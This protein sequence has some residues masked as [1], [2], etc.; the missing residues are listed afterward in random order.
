MLR[1]EV[2]AVE[3]HPGRARGS[4]RTRSGRRNERPGRPS[5][6]RASGD[7]L[8]SGARRCAVL[9]ARGARTPAGPALASPPAPRSPA[10][11]SAGGGRRTRPGGTVVY[12]VCTLNA[13]ENESVVDASGLE[14]EP[15]G[16]EWP[17]YAH[18]KRPEFL[19][20]RP[21]G[22]ARRGSSS[23]AS[24]SPPEPASGG[25]RHPSKSGGS[26]SVGWRCTSTI[27]R[28]SIGRLAGLRQG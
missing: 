22:T 17:A 13:D 21:T 27:G 10:R 23:R 28:S 14:P 15:L 2:T 26:S 11:A 24:R 3:L 7:R 16:A 20:P 19:L 5:D 18:P 12:S 25:S 9:R 1:A 8:R 4:R 6:A